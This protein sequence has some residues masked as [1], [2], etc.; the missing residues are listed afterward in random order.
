MSIL[1]QREDG[2]FKIV[3]NFSVKP[4]TMKAIPILES[5]KTMTFNEKSYKCKGAYTFPLSRPNQ[6]NLNGRI[7]TRGL[8][9]NVIVN[10]RAIWEGQYGL[11]DHP[12]GGGSVKDAFCVWH[13]LRFNEDKTLVIADAFLFGDW[14]QRAL[15]ALEAG[16]KIGLSSVGY[17]DFESDGKTICESTFEI[18]R[19][20]DWVMDP[21]YQVFGGADDVI[22]N[23]VVESAK[24]G[25][26]MEIN[27]KSVQS[28][29]EKTFR[30]SIDRYISE[31]AKIVGVEA[32][33]NKYNEIL[34]YFEGEIACPDLKEQLD[35]KI[36]ELKLEW[37][38]LAKKG[39]T[40]DSLIEDK[41]KVEL[42]LTESTTENAT[43]TENVADLTAKLSM[44]NEL[45]SSFKEYCEK[46]KEMYDALKEDIGSK[47]DATDLAEMKAYALNLQKEI[48]VLKKE[49]R[50]FKDDIAKY[51]A[52]KVSEAAKI[53][54]EDEA[55]KA[56]IAEDEALAIEKAAA[57][58]R[59]AELEV[60]N[61]KVTEMDF[62]NKEAVQDYY[63]DLLS[64][65][66]KVVGIKENILACKTV[67]EAQK[68]YLNL[69]DLV[70]EIIVPA[71][72]PVKDPLAEEF[73]KG[74]VREVRPLKKRANW[75]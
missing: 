17:G 60:L 2:K 39:L 42:S 7:Y 12:E 24:G 68:K 11:C 26:H 41:A 3:E 63:E 72:V 73:V 22:D 21:S 47:V 1:E 46:L 65:N 71:R 69:Q 70:E 19:P 29:E 59:I 30:M 34:A 4:S 16:G 67:V 18:D 45:V 48:T 55:A 37:N 20:A 43:L 75:I 49:R 62:S 13:N 5:M 6:E 58:A 40:T 64:A 50:G 51:E 10:Q 53:I 31:A 44:S 32:Q 57:Q 66:P 74:P 56:K 35:A 25:R 8:W 14:G 9:E 27:K 38:E 15:E 52:E 23:E 33:L 36:V 28:L 54:A 61:N